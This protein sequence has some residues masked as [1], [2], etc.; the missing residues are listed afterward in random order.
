MQKINKHVSISSRSFCQKTLSSLKKPVIQTQTYANLQFR[1]TQNQPSQILSA[2]IEQYAK[3]IPYTLS[4]YDILAHQDQMV[5]DYENKVLEYANLTGSKTVTEENVKVKPTT[6]PNF[7]EQSIYS[8]IQNSMKFLIRE[9]PIRIANMIKEMEELPENYK[10][11]DL[12]KTIY[13]N[14]IDSFEDLHKFT[15]ISD[16]SKIDLIEFCKVVKKILHRHGN[17]VNNMALSVVEYKRLYGCT[18]D[19]EECFIKFLDRFYQS[20][21]GIRLIL[22]HHMELVGASEVKVFDNLSKLIDYKKQAGMGLGNE[23]SNS[24]KL[25]LV[26]S[27]ERETHLSD[28]VQNNYD[29]AKQLCERDY[30]DSPKLVLSNPRNVKSS[31]VPSHLNYIFFEIIKNAMKATM[32]RYEKDEDVTSIPNINVGIYEGENDVTVKISDFGYGAELSESHRWFDYMYTTSDEGVYDSDFSRNSRSSIM[33]GFGVGLP[34]SRL[35][36]RYF[37]GDLK[38]LTR[39]GGGTDVYIYLKT[40]NVEKRE[41]LPNYVPE[42]MVYKRDFEVNKSRENWI[43]ISPQMSRQLFG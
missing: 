10:N 15:N 8:H 2:N 9:I 16:M 5:E 30:M 42:K 32:E 6:L 25:R 31:Y 7:L 20:R 14:Y 18:R 3:H 21:I 23:L 19:Q 37:S 29:I 4:I 17:T 36:A 26:S 28:I 34:L 12:F 22:S 1:A 39:Q 43:G 41:V 40:K 24:T 27:F 33:S 11:I 38:V 35:Y 13:D